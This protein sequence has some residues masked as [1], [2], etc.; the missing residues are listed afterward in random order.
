[1]THDDRT[2]LWGCSVTIPVDGLQPTAGSSPDPTGIT[3]YTT[4]QGYSKSVHHQFTF[5]EQDKPVYV[6]HKPPVGPLRGARTSVSFNNYCIERTEPDFSVSCETSLSDII[7]ATVQSYQYSSSDCTTTL[8][9]AFSEVHSAVDSTCALL[10]QGV[11]VFTFNFDFL[12]RLAVQTSSTSAVAGSS[13]EISLTLSNV[14]SINSRR[15]SSLCNGIECA[16]NHNIVV[17]FGTEAATILQDPMRCVDGTCKIRVRVPELSNS[18]TV[19]IT[20]Q[21]TGASSDG[22]QAS[23]DFNVFEYDCTNYCRR[24][25]QIQDSNL[26]ASEPPSSSDCLA[27]YCK[28][29][30]SRSPIIT[31][32]SNPEAGG[33]AECRYNDNCVVH[34]TV[35]QVTSH[36]LAVGL[37]STQQLFVTFGE[38]QVLAQAVNVISHDGDEIKLMVTTPVMTAADAWTRETRLLFMR[39]GAMRVLPRRMCRV[40]V[41]V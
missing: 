1:M 22:N 12:T 18:A 16:Y 5:T 3:V 38:T 15:A 28:A 8:T 11:Q 33:S 39:D 4:Q 40:S 41:R 29:P 14:K 10:V 6:S 7:V 36:I 24:L 25:G 30:P 35:S 21:P 17:L 9:V 32:I 23:F 19:T 2:D 20:N 37:V 26:V 34:V 13:P 31:S 27:M